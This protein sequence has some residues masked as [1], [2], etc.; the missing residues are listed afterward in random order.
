[1]DSTHS[2]RQEAYDYQRMVSDMVVGGH[3][4]IL[5]AP[6]GAGKTRA[7]LEPGIQGLYRNG[8]SGS[9][10]E[11]PP[12]IVYG[13]PMRVLARS[14][15][16]DYRGLAYRKAW[17]PEW[18]PTIQTGEQPEDELFEG[19]VI[20]AT[21][22]QMLASFLNLPYGL[23]R[24][25]G[26]INAGA[27]IGAYLV[28]DEFHLYPQQQMMLTA[29]AML[30]MLKGISRFTLMSATFSRRFLDALGDLLEADVVA[31]SPEELLFRDLTYLQSQER[32]W[33]AE[34][35]PLTGE[36]AAELIEDRER[37]LCICNTVDRAQALYRDLKDRLPEYEVR[38][39][40]SRF[41]RQDRKAI[42]DVALARLGNKDTMPEHLSR[43]FVL[44]ATQVVEV[45]LDISSEILLTECAPAASL[46]QRAGRCARWGGEGTVHI[47]QPYAL[48]DDGEW[49]VNYAPY[50]DEGKEAICE[51]TWE[52]L[53]SLEFR[54]RVLRFAKEQDL[55][56]RT[57]GP[58]D[59][60]WIG[61][62]EQ[63][64]MDRMG[65]ITD[66][67][68]EPD[69]GWLGNLIRNNMRVPLYV[70]PDPNRDEHLTGKPWR[71]E[72]F[73]LSKGQVTRLFEGGTIWGGQ[74]EREDDP[75]T[76]WVKSVY[77]W[78]GLR[79]AGEA[80][81]NW[82]FV[83]HPEAVSYSA[84]EGLRLHPGP[85]PAPPSPDEAEASF[86]RPDY[87]PERYH[88]HVAGLHMAYTL[89]QTVSKRHK[90]GRTADYHRLPLRDELA[91]PLDRL[92]ARMNLDA[93]LGER[94][95]RLTL[96]LHDLGKLNRPW[97]AW[98]RAWQKYL[99]EAG[100]DP[101]LPLDDPDPLAHTRFDK[102]SEA[103]RELQRKLKHPG[104]GTHAVEGAEA[105]LELLRH[106][107]HD[108][109]IWLAVALAA[110]MRHHTPTAE[111]CGAFAMVEEGQAALERALAE[112]GFD[113]EAPDWALQ[114]QTEFSRSGYE[115]DDAID[116]VT[117]FLNSYDPGL[118]YFVFVRCL[119]L[120]DQRSGRYW[121]SYK[122]EWIAR[123][124]VQ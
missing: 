4:L 12:R 32:T 17:R 49:E 65:V 53:S 51:R 13:V 109:E 77:K 45:G 104:R 54:G 68:R 114:A 78:Y 111:K 93:A 98:A 58:A 124:E 1:M 123:N 29:L 79:E 88:E 56:D 97:Q 26:N 71:R 28:F 47:F 10:T 122:D 8:N 87:H 63:K 31:E 59:E 6:T 99:S 60:E 62:L 80:Y 5:Q 7:A 16:E 24:R 107:C 18:N 108:E 21:V 84:E 22:D 110:I 27:L 15:V 57:H 90:D 34:D 14:F 105:T 100:H 73:S 89:P 75:E 117:P 74:E 42:E 30:K 102:A 96:V 121:Q 81:Q 72:S 113:A 103:H 55:I 33:H 112:C 25:L 67:M 82:M 91:Y 95:M 44:V 94:L 38:L 37:A 70:H 85:A 106:A 76:P 50:L 120:A 20:F 23:P 9:H 119:R 64:V 116:T 43:P 48:N 46:I 3:D 11:H 101:E 61:G 83:A 41:Y 36:R 35:G 69:P 2:A 115:L 40:H 66:C 52:A 86:E 118:L 92:C 39:L 19:K